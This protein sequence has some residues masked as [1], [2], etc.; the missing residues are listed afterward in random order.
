[1][2]RPPSPSSSMHFRLFRRELE[3]QRRHFANT[4]RQKLRHR[5]WKNRARTSGFARARRRATAKAIKKGNGESRDSL[6]AAQGRA[7][8]EELKVF[9]LLCLSGHLIEHLNT[10]ETEEHKKHRGLRK[11]VQWLSSWF[12]LCFLCSS[13]F[14]KC[15][16]PS[17]SSRVMRNAICRVF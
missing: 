4:A 2:S 3:T 17:S 14:K 5:V 7:V 8:L 1:M 15:F 12:S 16:C 6:E 10:E 11:S 13:V 9:E